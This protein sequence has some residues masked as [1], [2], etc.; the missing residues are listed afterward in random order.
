MSACDTCP[1][2]GACCRGLALIHPSA[3]FATPLQA[4]VAMVAWDL[5]FLP[6]DSRYEEWRNA[7]WSATE[8]RRAFSFDCINLTPDGR[9]GDY[10]N[11]P[12]LCRRYEPG[13][14]ALCAIWSP[15]AELN[16]PDTESGSDV[17]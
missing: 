15:P 14:D 1:K 11:R 7:E 16:A 6:V 2:P 10:E 3:Y 13:Q 8:Q 5:P 17:K 12:G 9:C 4:L